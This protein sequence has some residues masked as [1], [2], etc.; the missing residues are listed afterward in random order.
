[1]KWLRITIKDHKETL[2]DALRREGYSVRADCG[3]RGNCGKCKVRILEPGAGPERKEEACSWQQA[4]RV[5]GKGTYQVGIPAYTEDEIRPAV[6]SPE[7]TADLPRDRTALAVDIGTTTIAAALTDTDSGR[8]I[9]T[10]SCMNSQRSYGSDVLSRIDAANRGLGE[11]LRNLMMEDLDLLCRQLGPGQSVEAL[12]I[13][14]FISGNTTMEHLLQGLS[15]RNLGHWPFRP[16]DI[17]LHSYKNMTILPGISTFV[18][19]DTVS[20]IVAC[21]MDQKKE[22]SILVDLGTNGE[23]AIGNRDRILV[24]STAAGPAFEGGNISCGMASVPGAADRVVIRKGKVT[25][26][27]IGGGRPAGLCGTGVLETV[28]EL[29][30]EGIID[31]NGLMDDRWFNDGYPL[32][33]GLTFTQKDV[34]EVQLAKGAVRAGIEILMST[35]GVTGEE[36]DRVFLAGSFGQKLNTEKAAAIGLIPES[37]AGR[38]V[39]AGN[40]SLAGAVMAASDPS[41]CRRMEHVVSISEEIVLSNREDFNELYLQYMSF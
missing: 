4:C 22:I 37:L 6:L 14:V 19:A 24:T 33:E 25:M 20:G 30:R 29:L 9:K 18:G 13:P 21:G 17:S 38:I 2:L 34:R 23:M 12:S 28:H 26:T 1:M 41:V 5:R 11:E 7:N 32:A 3:G 35:Y 31:R 10:A 39:S 15:C 40:T 16:E 8:V 36:I 27:T